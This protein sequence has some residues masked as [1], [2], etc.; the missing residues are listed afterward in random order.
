M[1]TTVSLDLDDDVYIRDSTPT[2]NYNGDNLKIGVGFN[3]PGVVDRV[4]IHKDVTAYLGATVSE[5]HIAFVS[6][7]PDLSGAAKARR[8]TTISW[9]EATATWN[10]PWITPGLGVSDYT[11]VGEVDWVTP[12]TSSPFNLIGLAALLQ[13]A[14]DNRGGQFHLLLHLVDEITDSHNVGFR[15]SEYN[16]IPTQ[17][18]KLVFT[19]DMNILDL[20][21]IADPAAIYSGSDAPYV[22]MRIAG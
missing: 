4:V 20:P 19:Y 1:S 21:D 12:V 7:T 3:L 16:P 8:I 5:A 15:D 22:R 13:D 14:L 2:T 17:R 18:P 11:T 10:S 6:F 9:A